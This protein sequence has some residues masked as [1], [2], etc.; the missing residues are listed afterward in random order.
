[1]SENIV[2]TKTV[3]LSTSAAI[4]DAWTYFFTP[5]DFTKSLVLTDLP[6]YYQATIRITILSP[7]GTARV[8]TLVVGTSFY[9]GIT[10]QGASV[11]ITSYSKKVTDDFGNITITK[12]GYSKRFTGDTFFDMLMLDGV[13]NIL[14][15]YKDIPVVWIGTEYGYS[16]LV[17]YGFYKSF[18]INIAG[19]NHC[20]CSLDLEGLV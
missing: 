3:Q 1:M 15:L 8:G 6:P 4:I 18:S 2:Y 16:A 14:T 10:Q 9:L 11:G 7:G 20:I 5:F 13:Q 12:R 19:P 17:L